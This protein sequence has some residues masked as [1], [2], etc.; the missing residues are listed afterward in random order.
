MSDRLNARDDAAVPDLPEFTAAPNGGNHA[1]G[2]GLFPIHPF[3]PARAGENAMLV[4][5]VE[6]A[7]V[8]LG[9]GD[10]LEDDRLGVPGGE[11]YVDGED[12][13]D[14]VEGDPIVQVAVWDTASAAGEDEEPDRVATENFGSI[15]I[16]DDGMALDLPSE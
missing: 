16:E 1:H 9:G 7:G 3:S 10:Q 8:V 13:C 11:T 6:D 15:R 14:G 2:D 4:D 12:S 5:W